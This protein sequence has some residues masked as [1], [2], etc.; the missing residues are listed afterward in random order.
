MKQQPTAYYAIQI[1]NCIVLYCVA[2]SR[3]KDPEPD[4]SVTA[5]MEQPD[6][7]EA[8]VLSIANRE[9][10]YIERMM[11]ASTVAPHTPHK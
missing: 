9:R 5:P 6:L 3:D 2:V 1:T 7:R 4:E 11:R 8:A 10:E